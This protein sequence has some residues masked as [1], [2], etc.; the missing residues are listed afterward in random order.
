M[1]VTSKE[2]TIMERGQ[3]S[4]YYGMAA[5]A[6]LGKQIAGDVSSKARAEALVA[7]P[8]VVV[9]DSESVSLSLRPGEKAVIPTRLRYR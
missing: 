5:N 4:K 1:K 8:P 2:A 3:H 9:D 7:E 6:P